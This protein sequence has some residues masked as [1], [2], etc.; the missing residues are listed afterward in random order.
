MLFKFKWF[1]GK[2]PSGFPG[3]NRWNTNTYRN[4][5]VCEK[6]I[7][8]LKANNIPIVWLVAILD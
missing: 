6:R 7:A 1:Q 2:H 3:G 5:D 8:F 4:W